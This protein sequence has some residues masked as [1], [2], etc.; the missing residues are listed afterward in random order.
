PMIP[1]FCCHF[2]AAGANPGRNFAGKKHWPT[3]VTGKICWQ[4]IFD[5]SQLAIAAFNI[6]SGF[7]PHGSATPATLI[8]NFISF[9][10]VLKCCNLQIIV[11]A[12]GHII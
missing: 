3:D 7:A 9:W 5:E 2:C 11:I 1:L 6:Q 12:P 4:L 10:L 8:F